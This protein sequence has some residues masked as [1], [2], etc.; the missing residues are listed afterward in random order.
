MLPAVNDTAPRLAH[1]YRAFAAAVY[2]GRVGSS[3]MARFTTRGALA[4]REGLENYRRM[5]VERR[6]EGLRELFPTVAAHLGQPRFS[7]LV[8]AYLAGH[9]SSSP[10]LERVGDRFASFLALAGEARAAR[11]ASLEWASLWIFLAPDEPAPAP[12]SFPDATELPEAVLDL[13]RAFEVVPLDHDDRLA[14]SSAGGQPIS[15]A[16]SGAP[17]VRVALRAIEAE[18]AE[19]LARARSGEPFASVCEPFASSSDPVHAALG[20]VRR[21]LDVGVLRGFRVAS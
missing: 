14:W 1:D 19:S 10:A 17:A 11:L 12:L 20:C 3:E 4:I 8:G 2:D 9:V 6:V 5:Y 21:W 7:S 13:A 16:A 15:D 18:E